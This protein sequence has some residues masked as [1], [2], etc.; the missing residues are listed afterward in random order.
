[1][2]AMLSFAPNSDAVTTACYILWQRKKAW[3]VCFC[4]RIFSLSDLQTIHSASFGHGS[5]ANAKQRIVWNNVLTC[6]GN[7]RRADHIRHVQVFFL[8]EKDEKATHV[9]FGQF[10]VNSRDCREVLRRFPRFPLDSPFFLPH[11]VEQDLEL[12][13]RLGHQTIGG[14]SARSWK[15]GVLSCHCTLS[16]HICSF[17][18]CSFLLR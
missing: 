7:D 16:L 17:G 2:N 18:I 6:G 10:K 12:R 1:M 3:L 15:V 4:T 14:D 5:H 8:R 11:R 9:I 13:T